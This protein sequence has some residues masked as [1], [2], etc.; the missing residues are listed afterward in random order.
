MIDKLPLEVERY[1]NRVLRDAALAQ[2]NYRNV[3]ARRQ[4]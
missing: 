2:P 4:Q 1:R 3:L